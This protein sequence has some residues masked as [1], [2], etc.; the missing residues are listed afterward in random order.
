MSG[1][2]RWILAIVVIALVVGLLAYARG[3]EHFH[4][5]EEGAMVGEVSV[6]RHASS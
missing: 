3:P 2:G 4:G 5:D 1:T 6:T